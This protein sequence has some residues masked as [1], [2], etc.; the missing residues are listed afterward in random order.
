M[1]L[2][3]TKKHSFDAVYDSQKVYR[4]ILEAMSNPGEIVNIKEYADKLYGSYP[5]FLAVAMALLDNEVGFHACGNLPLADE[6]ESLKLAGNA[7][8][9][10]ADYIFAGNHRV[11]ESAIENAKYGTLTDPHKSAT[12]IIQNNGISAL[13][14]T[15]SGPGIDGQAEFMVT[16]TVKDAIMMRDAQNFEYPQGIDLLFISGAGELFAIPRLVKVV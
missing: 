12:V 13:C 2:Q 15:L 10:E 1:T 6:I 5:A 9:E 14:L 7:N 11:I 8:I 4:L 3:L 16:Q